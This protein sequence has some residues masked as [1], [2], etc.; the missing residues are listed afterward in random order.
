MTAEAGLRGKKVFVTGADG[1]I[2]SHLAER[3][4]R[5]GARVRAL[6]L[7]NPQGSAGWLDT[8]S[9]EVR[10]E[11][12]VRLGDIRDARFMEDA[13]RDVEVVFHLAALISIPYSYEAPASYVETNV[14]GTLHVLEAARR[15]GCRRVIHTS[16]SEVYGTPETTPITESHPLRAQSPYAA[17]KIGADQ[18]ALS[19]H[20]SFE[21]PVVVLRPFNTYGP[22]QSTRAILPSLLT[23]MLRGKRQ[24]AVGRLDPRRDLTFVGDTVEGFLRAAQAPGIEGETIQLGTGQ[25]VSMAELFELCRQCVG[26][27]AAP[28][29]QA[30]RVRPDKSEVLVLLSDPARAK[31][32]LGWQPQVGIAEG[33]GQTA[34]WLERNL[35][36]YPGQRLHV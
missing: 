10:A 12:D 27:D 29:V 11:M 16:T 14:T 31:A 8:I 28:V 2:G 22:R 20:R 18:L 34:R 17:T 19:Y 24:I 26:I 33:L 9:P 36:R 1:F 3:L 35:D 5:E 21:T 25:A 23:Q 7:Y 13:C 15:V 30:E 6:G 4:V 32:R